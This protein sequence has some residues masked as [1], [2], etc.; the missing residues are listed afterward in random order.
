MT[1]APVSTQLSASPA[2]HRPVAWIRRRDDVSELT[3]PHDVR[4]DDVHVSPWFH[5][6]QACCVLSVRMAGSQEKAMYVWFI[7]WT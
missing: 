4:H 1:S 3:Q 5:W 6:T 2:V 7:M